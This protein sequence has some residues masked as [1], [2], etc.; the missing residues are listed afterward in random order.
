MVNS[1]T[2]D[3]IN[4]SHSYQ[5][6]KS[7]LYKWFTTL[8]YRYQKSYWCWREKKKSVLYDSTILSRHTNT[9]T[10]HIWDGAMPPKQHK[11]SKNVPQQKSCGFWFVTTF[12]WKKNLYDAFLRHFSPKNQ[13][14][15]SGQ[16]P[17]PWGNSANMQFQLSTLSYKIAYQIWLS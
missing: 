6:Y 2:P 5:L 14:V 11:I 8:K 15:Q 1:K 13:I 10:L 17:N 9:H 3:A 16:R 4:W 12:V 7:V